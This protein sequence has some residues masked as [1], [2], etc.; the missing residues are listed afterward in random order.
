LS[1]G[2]KLFLKGSA[3]I[4]SLLWL[5]LIVILQIVQVLYWAVFLR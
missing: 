2:T 3:E 5:D 4:N 1:G